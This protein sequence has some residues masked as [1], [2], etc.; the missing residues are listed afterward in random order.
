MASL[1]GKRVL[2]TGASRGIGRSTARTLAEDGAHLVLVVRDRNL[3]EAVKEDCT[4]RGAASCELLVADLSSM[5]AVR[6]I[7]AEYKE[8]WQELHVLVDNAGAIYAERKTT[9]DGL[10]MTFAVNHLAY[11]LLTTELLELLER[12][13]PARVVVVASNAHRRGKIRWDDLQSE[14]SYFSPA[15]YGTTKLMNILFARE[16]ARRLAGKRVT[17][18]SLHPGVIASSFGVNNKGLVGLAWKLAA[19]FLMNEDDGARTTV[20][21]ARDPSVEGVTG[22]YFVRCKERSPTK[23]AEDDDAARRLWEVSE[24]ILARLGG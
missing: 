17:A 2:I 9:E 10:E 20:F 15:V 16:L 23:A 1:E 18:N 21:L 3:G 4:K 6:R 22:K 14:R 5:K 7:A 19:P 13:A 12:S 11:F 8:R 24:E